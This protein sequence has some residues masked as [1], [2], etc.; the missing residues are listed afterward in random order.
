MKV[1]L[2][3]APVEALFRPPIGSGRMG[4]FQR[5]V[6]KPAHPEHWPVLWRSARTSH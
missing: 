4:Q 5:S 1:V 2:S 6:L 3:W